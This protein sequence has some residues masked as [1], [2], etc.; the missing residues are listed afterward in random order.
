M[1]TSQGSAQSKIR[2]TISGWTAEVGAAHGELSG[3]LLETNAQLGRLLEVLVNKV[4]H[5]AELA[6]AQDEIERLKRQLGESD[7]LAGAVTQYSAGVSPAIQALRQEM[8]NALNRLNSTVSAWKLEVTEAHHGLS[9]QIEEANRQFGL[10]LE[11]MEQSP[12]APDEPNYKALD[13]LVMQQ[14]A[15]IQDLRHEKAVL[16]TQAHALNVEL[17]GLQQA[18][19]H[20][21]QEIQLAAESVALQREDELHKVRERLAAREAEIQQLVLENEGL[22]EALTGAH[23][24]SAQMEAEIQADRDR[25]HASLETMKQEMVALHDRERDHRMETQKLLEELSQQPPGVDPSVLEAAEQRV[26]ELRAAIEEKDAR[27]AAQLDR[28]AGLDKLVWDLQQQADALLEAQDEAGPSREELARELEA[29]RAQRDAL[30]QENMALAARLTAL[31]AAKDEEIQALRAARDELASE[32][33]AL[34]TE[35]GALREQHGALSAAH[36]A[37]AVQV[38]VLQAE[39]TSHRE[40]LQAAQSEKD[41]AE[42]RLAAVEE[43]LAQK[44]QRLEGIAGEV[45]EKRMVLADRETELQAAYERIDRLEHELENARNQETAL[46]SAQSEL[47]RRLEE[48]QRNLAAAQEAIAK[49]EA[50][51]SHEQSLFLSRLRVE[52]LEADLRTAQDRLGLLKQQEQD[53]SQRTQDLTRALGMAR[54]VGEKERELQQREQELAA[55]RTEMEAVSRELEALQESLAASTQREAS[56][57][58]RVE[59]LTAQLEESAHLAADQTARIDTV[60]ASA[61]TLKGQTAA[62]ETELQ[63][64]HAALENRDTAHAASMEEIARLQ[65][66]LG[67][68]KAALEAE[69]E[70]VAVERAG[71]VERSAEAEHQRLALEE[72]LALSAADIGDLQ[73]ALGG[74]RERLA[75]VELEYGEQQRA[76]A[77]ERAAMAETARAMGL[78]RDALVEEIAAYETALQQSAADRAGLA[79]QA[80]LI[81]EQYHAQRAELDGLKLETLGLMEQLSDAANMLAA[82]ESG[83]RAALDA[84][85]RRA[86]DYADRESGSRSLLDAITRERAELGNANSALQAQHAALSQQLADSQAALS[87][88]QPE[89]VALQARAEALEE[90]LESVR[91][92]LHD[93]E[94][95]WSMEHDR[96][97][98]RIAELLEEQ[99]LLEEQAA[100]PWMETRILMLEAEV[101][102]LQQELMLAAAGSA[103]EATAPGAREEEQRAALQDELAQLQEELGTLQA[104]YTD[105]LD[106]RDALVEQV[107]TAGMAYADQ[108]AD[109]ESLRA[110]L[111]AERAQNS[112]LSGQAEALRAESESLEQ[113]LAAIRAAQTTAMMQSEGAVQAIREAALGQ[114]ALLVEREAAIGD[115]TARIAVLEEALLEQADGPSAAEVEESA[116]QLDELNRVLAGAQQAYKDKALALEESDR[117]LK[118]SL[119]SHATAEDRIADLERQVRELRGALTEMEQKEA[120]VQAQHESFIQEI[121]ALRRLEQTRSAALDK[122]QSE[123]AAGK[124]ALAARETEMAALREELRAGSAALEALRAEMAEYERRMEGL[125]AEHAAQSDQCAAF[126]REVEAQQT[127]L[128]EAQR[129]LQSRAAAHDEQRAAAQNLETETAR[130]QAL[131]DESGTETATRNAALEEALIASQALELRQQEALQQGAA[132]LEAQKDALAGRERELM[133]LDAALRE[134][135]EALAEANARESALAGALHVARSAEAQQRAGLENAL[136]ALTAQSEALAAQERETVDLQEHMQDLQ[137]ELSALSKAEAST[138]AQMES[139]REE[140]ALAREDREGFQEHLQTRESDIESLH[141]QLREQEEQLDGINQERERLQETVEALKLYEAQYQADLKR[142]QKNLD[143]QQEHLNHRDVMLRQVQDKFESLETQLSAA[144]TE[145]ARHKEKAEQVMSELIRAVEE[146][147]AALQRAAAKPERGRIPM[148]IAGGEPLLDPEAQQQQQ[149]IILAERTIREGHKS[150]GEILVRAGIIDA[151]QL[152]EALKMQETSPGQLLGTILINLDMATDTAI[153]QAVASQCGIPMV[154]PL[155][156]QISAEARD[157]LHKDLCAWHVCIPMRC[158]K[159][160]IVVAMANP[161]DESARRKIE[162]MS[163][164]TVEPVVAAASTIMRAIEDVYGDL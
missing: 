56:M 98:A 127:Q 138:Q 99:Q 153:A 86:A 58:Q 147:D 1:G 132:A 18:Q 10:L 15:L 150:L 27:L 55:L 130:L 33:E 40:A 26:Q 42:G 133:A 52:S 39:L 84:A 53:W 2:A 139:L 80:Q 38:S 112:A 22:A 65:E 48:V 8:L 116:R 114:Q 158:T 118:D 45:D 79:E 32:S 6:A 101:A 43:Q 4:E 37:L 140:I 143:A 47:Q 95:T 142:A 119:L 75:A 29:V 97:E 44:A 81:E 111:Q 137:E 69:R 83:F 162:D 17:E 151:E 16:T 70:S 163:R 123:T 87:A 159:D 7:L 145:S 30:A 155:P 46:A 31:Q 12:I 125:L 25:L 157:L 135:K 164:R 92:E 124:E 134:A 9:Q 106:E 24:Q 90:T 68:L 144:N 62:L 19:E 35:E 91:R 77:P 85:E 117:A 20:F 78:E 60:E 59:F 93:R 50:A 149:E 5:T 121:E 67:A 82:R 161:L 115:L 63:E 64:A 148:G 122:A 110:A 72:A 109:R 34:R 76:W 104:R 23:T 156:A 49:D 152:V 107:Q 120:L 88:M 14:E 13:D 89:S 154:T 21:T 126:Q 36:D 74:S 146:R 61:R 105:L 94:A 28:C 71:F 113:A 57:R 102:E 160:C 103:Q 96:F 131:L 141:Q 129:E 108:D 3:Q 66:E 128:E 54:E 11:L 41:I 136:A 73:A 51:Q 100:A